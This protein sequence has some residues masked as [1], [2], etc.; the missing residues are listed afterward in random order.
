MRKVLLSIIAV[1]FGASL[2]AQITLEKTFAATT[3][4][5]ILHSL[6]YVYNDLYGSEVLGYAVY[7][8]G[9]GTIDVF[10]TDYTL[11]LNFAIDIPEGYESYSSP[12]VNQ[13]LFNEDDKV[14]FVCQ[15]KKSGSYDYLTRIFNEDGDVL[16]EKEIS[17]FMYHKADNKFMMT[18]SSYK[19]IEDGGETKYEYAKEIYSIRETA[20]DLA[21]GAKLL[22]ANP[23]PNPA[24]HTINLPYSLNGN[25][26]ADMKIMNQNGQLIDTKSVHAYFDH[27][28]LDVSTYPQGVYFYECNGVSSKFIVTK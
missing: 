14:E 2:Q 10:N 15:F 9:E 12:F 17:N 23:Y 5:P 18:A 28:K 27:I 22:T 20:V 4:E 3:T 1:L 8:S 25:A 24:M 13:Y 26:H 7:H 11:R 16:F 21:E 19:M 6:T